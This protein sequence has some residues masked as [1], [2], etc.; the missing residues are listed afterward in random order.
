MAPFR[1][2]GGGRWERGG[3]AGVRPGLGRLSLPPL[4]TESAVSSGRGPRSRF[5][6]EARVL[7]VD[8]EPVS[9]V[10]LE[11]LLR[12]DGCR[13]VHWTSDPFEAL[14]CFWDIEPDLVLLDLHMP[15][16]SGLEV[17]SDLRTSLSSDT[18]LP[19]LVLTADQSPSTKKE[20]LRSG[21]TDFLTKPFDPTEVSLRIGNLLETRGLHLQ[22]LSER[23]S[24]E[25]RVSERT[26][27]LSHAQ[28]E[29]LRRL[30]LAAEYRDDL[31][32]RHA[33]RVGL[34]ASLLA[35]ELGASRHRVSLIRRAATLHDIGKIGVPD[36][37]LGKPGRLSQ[38]EFGQMKQH[39][40]IGRQ[41][42]AG[43]AFE[44]LRLAEEIAESHHE[45]WDGA[46]YPRGLFG[47]AIPRAARIT[48]VA[49]VYDSL[50][51]DRP[52]RKALPEEQ[53]AEMIGSESGTHFDP[54]VVT[55]FDRLM[56]M[57]ELRERI[58][59][60]VEDRA[61]LGLLSSVDDGA[62]FSPDS[63]SASDSVS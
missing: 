3:I 12:Q 6:E 11:R 25:E 62:V 45:R 41:I 49:D 8:D 16:R 46:G 7:I 1:T 56:G 30:A 13:E 28:A 5:H 42:L 52:Y 63:G 55:A 27:D 39:T 4:S 59:D 22:V 21:A 36:A 2:K 31:T 9:C 37:V 23:A 34:L 24:L 48:A 29:L 10:G 51:H 14:R 61:H 58:S 53:A 57:G 44:M 33:E 43:S 54:A 40:V 17:L 18:Y 50:T 60:A 35:R 20:A 38:A 19:V 15:E 32:G 47:E 26:R